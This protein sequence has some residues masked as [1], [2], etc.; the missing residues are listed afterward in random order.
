[1]LR[2]ASQTPRG[3]RL[4]PF[5]TRT[6]NLPEQMVLYVGL[7]AVGLLAGLGVSIAFDVQLRR[8]GLRQGIGLVL[9]LFVLWGILSLTHA[10]FT[11]VLLP[12]VWIGTGLLVGLGS[13][14]THPAG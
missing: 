9:F 2:I 7:Y 1:M 5:S 4:I 10:A 14:Q 11:Q 13:R 6:Y 12:L 8:P 3:S